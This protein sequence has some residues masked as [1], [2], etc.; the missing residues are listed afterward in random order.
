MVWKVEGRAPTLLQRGDPKT[1]VSE[2][3]G[4]IPYC[5]GN[6]CSAPRLVTRWA[7]HALW[8]PIFRAISFLFTAIAIL[9]IPYFSPTLG[10]VDR[11]VLIIS[12]S[13]LY[14]AASS[15]LAA[16]LV[17]RWVYG[18]GPLCTLIRYRNELIGRQHV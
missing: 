1:Y 13:Y 10:L 16:W 5:G 8:P 7:F 11:G 14:C 2:E 4:R 18:A 12:I 6:D 17:S 3:S 15:L 9:D